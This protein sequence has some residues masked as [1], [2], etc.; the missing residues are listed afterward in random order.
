LYDYFSLIADEIADGIGLVTDNNDWF[1]A[2]NLPGG[3][4]G[5]PKYWFAQERMENFRQGRTHARA[6]PC[7]KNHCCGFH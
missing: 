3:F 5:I 6:L 1:C 7:G 2:G 4:K